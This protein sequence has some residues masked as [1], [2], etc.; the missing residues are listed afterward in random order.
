MVYLVQGNAQE[1][2]NAFGQ[3]WIIRKTDENSANAIPVDLVKTKFL[4][5]QEQAAHFVQ[6]WRDSS[7]PSFY[8][9]GNISAASLFLILGSPYKPFKKP[10]ESN[11]EYKKNYVRKDF[12]YFSDQQ[13]P[14]GLMLIY[15]KDLPSQWMI[16]L[17]KNNHLAPEDRTVVLLSSFD[18]KP[19]IKLKNQGIE[20]TSVDLNRNSL[21]DQMDSSTVQSQ[22]KRIIK[23]DSA[24]VDVNNPVIE[25]LTSNILVN[26]LEGLHLS[27][28]LVRELIIKYN[29]MVTI[30]TLGTIDN[31][32]SQ[33]LKEFASLELGDDERLNKNLLQMLVVFLEDGTLEQNRKLLQDHEYIKAMGALMWDPAQIRLIPLLRD[34]HYSLDL[35]QL[36]LSREAYYGSFNTLVQ[37]GLTQ[38]VPELFKSPEKLNQ[39]TYINSL[40]DEHRRKLCLIFWVKGNLS[41]PELEQIVKATE[42]YPLL[43]ETL[44]ALDQTQKII[45]IKDL[46]KHALNPLIHVQKSILYHYA[47]QFDKHSLTKSDLIKLDLDELNELNNSLNVLKQTGIVSSDEYRLV[48]KKNNQGQILR[49]FLPELS[50][51]DDVEQRKVLLNLLYKGVQKGVVSQGKALLEIKDKD[52]ATIAHDLRKRF[53]CVKQMQ[54]LSFTNEVIALA[55]KADSIAAKRF[56]HVIFRVE[57]Q[58]KAVHERLRKSSS[59]RDIVGKWQRADEEYRRSLYSIAYEGVTQTGVD[60]SFKINQAETKILNIVDPEIKSWLQKILIVIANILITTLTLGIANDFKERNTGNYWFFTQTPSGEELRVLDKDVMSLINCPDSEIA[61]LN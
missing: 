49:L 24:E 13:E 8:A 22:I 47:L 1:I 26:N 29:L 2:F 41:L 50:K 39:L 51:I 45:S 31:A 35:I 7:Q 43:A 40:T 10:D 21:F 60:L 28:N 11:S 46:K 3:E 33:L 19:Y 15:R 42:Q 30:N 34:K 18:L 14:C 56:R 52:L 12:A 4:G 20:V 59:D 57:E 54:D 5:T 32:E 61:Q 9:Q 27:S 53:I 36:I 25:A 37:L 44:V 55:G 38:D 48:M 23:S 58:C 16:G 17:M 6:T